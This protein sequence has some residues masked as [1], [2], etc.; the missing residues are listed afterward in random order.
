ME[1]KEKQEHKEV[2]KREKREKREKTGEDYCIDCYLPIGW[3]L[4]SE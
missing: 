4:F 2:E 1:K 3:D